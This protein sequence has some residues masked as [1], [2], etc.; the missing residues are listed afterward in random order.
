MAKGW[1]YVDEDRCKGCALC[2]TACPQSVLALSTDRFNAKG[3]RPVELVD[4]DNC[5]G[6]TICA[7]VCPDVIFTV[8]RAARKKK[9]VPQA[10]GA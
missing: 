6:C 3:Y 8:Y 7:I 10:A 1:V 5:T 4:P 9:A 2:V